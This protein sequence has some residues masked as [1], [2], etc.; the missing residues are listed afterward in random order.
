MELDVLLRFF[1]INLMLI[2][3]NF[4]IKDKCKTYAFAYFEI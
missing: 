2:A 4:M 3:I 1:S